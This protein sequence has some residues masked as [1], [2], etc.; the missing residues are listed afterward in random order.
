MIT[1]KVMSNENNLQSNLHYVLDNNSN[2][3]EIKDNNMGTEISNMMKKET[4]T[5]EKEITTS[6]SC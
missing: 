4:V 2:E 6:K 3:E 1:R 5:K